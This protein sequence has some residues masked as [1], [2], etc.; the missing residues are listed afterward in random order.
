MLQTS[1]R[2]PSASDRA[3]IRNFRHRGDASPVGEDLQARFNEAMDA[4][5]PNWP[6]AVAASGGSDSTAL[7]LLLNEWARVRGLAPPALLTV[8]HG[9]RPDSAR[10]TQL[11]RALADHLGLA[12]TALIWRG[13]KPTSNV[14]A[15][16]RAARYGLLGKWCVEHGC[17]ALYVGH[18]LEDQAETFL[19]RLGR[20]SGLDGL[21]CM[22]SVASV[23]LEAVH[24]V[25]LMRPLLSFGR[26]A[27]RRFL[28]ERKVD[29]FED[30]MNRDVRFSRAKLRMAW[31]EL[32]ALGLSPARIAQ[33]A[34]H[35]ARAR[36]ALDES[37]AAFLETAVCF[38]QNAAT[39][40]TMRFK[41]LPRET[42]LRVLAE[43][44]LKVS[45]AQYRPR[46]VRLERLFDAIIADSLGRGAT[47][48]GCLVVP[49]T[50][51]HRRF[52]PATIRISPE[53]RRLKD[54]DPAP[55]RRCE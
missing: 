19:I 42:G 14:E 30:P 31:P 28:Q 35:L 9:L 37:T 23:P 44:L 25:Q 38:E 12:F 27:L 55:P 6:G 17:P 46:F 11:V 40:D 15:Q 49:A 54:P 26:E 32:Q 18:T 16:A 20:G 50:R 34:S 51:A 24:Q 48:Q 21:S 43:V 5:Q 41:L 8:E 45:G 36:E 39:L 29:W 1:E 13:E 3:E 52:G 47:L 10:Q 2:Q 22:Q 7:V 4:V 33:A 53:K